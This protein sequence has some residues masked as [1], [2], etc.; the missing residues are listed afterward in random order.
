MR[1]WKKNA[2]QLHK[3]SVSETSKKSQVADLSFD[4]EVIPLCKGQ[5]RAVGAVG[6]PSNK[7]KPSSF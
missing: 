1:E 5:G 2:Q 7:C 3:S 6:V 4:Q